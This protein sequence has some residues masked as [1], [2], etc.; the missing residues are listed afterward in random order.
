MPRSP[1][2]PA[3]PATP[4]TLAEI[5]A[6]LGRDRLYL[7]GWIKRFELP[8]GHGN[9]YPATYPSFFRTVVFLRLAQIPEEKL[10]E[11]WTLEKKLMN[12]LHVDTSGSPTWMIDGHSAAGNDSRRLF[13]SRFD[14][15]RPAKRLRPT[16]I[17]F[18]G[19]TGG[20]LRWPGHGRGR[21]EAT[22][23]LPGR[24]E[25][26]AGH[27]GLS[28]RPAGGSSTVGRPD[29]KAVLTVEELDLKDVEHARL[30]ADQHREAVKALHGAE[31]KIAH[32]G[33][34]RD[35]QVMIADGMQSGAE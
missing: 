27:G 8:P 35:A 23:D 33:G 19:G 2:P 24:V 5:V 22:G 7:L 26:G 25:A 4:S 15:H 16:G 14:M 1:R 12:L 21:P 34:V 6:A 29:G 31:L 10:V 3:P 9:R 30:L 32:L 11:L 17:G 20:T 28:V 13:L 18:L